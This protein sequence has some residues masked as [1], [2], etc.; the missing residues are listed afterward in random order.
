MFWDLAGYQEVMAGWW[1]GGV[2]RPC[3]PTLLLL[4]ESADTSG[5]SMDIDG[6]ITE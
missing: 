5:D 4:S 6:P 3:V 2:A 1:S